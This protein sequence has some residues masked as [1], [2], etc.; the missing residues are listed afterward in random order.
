MKQTLDNARAEKQQI[1]DK[2]P[3]VAAISPGMAPR[4]EA[5]DSDGGDEEEAAPIAST[6]EI[7]RKGCAGCATSGADGGLILVAFALLLRTR[8]RGRRSR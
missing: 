8:R 5:Y 1:I 4:D 6:S 7:Q 2:H 3:D